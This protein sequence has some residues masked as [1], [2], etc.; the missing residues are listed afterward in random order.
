MQ[1]SKSIESVTSVASSCRGGEKKASPTH[2][3]IQREIDNKIM[4]LP[5]THL[6]N[7]S[8]TRIKINNTATFKVDNNSRK[9]YR[10]NIIQLGT[11]EICMEQFQVFE[12][13]AGADQHNETDDEIHETNENE[14]YDERK[15]SSKKQV[16]TSFKVHERI[17]TGSNPGL[18][19]SSTKQT[20]NIVQKK[21]HLKSKPSQIDEDLNEPS[22]NEDEEYRITTNDSSYNNISS[23]K[24]IHK[25]TTTTLKKNAKKTSTN[26]FQIEHQ[27]EQQRVSN[28]QILI[29][30]Q[31]QN[32]H[33][34]E[35]DTAVLVISNSEQE[36]QL[37]NIGSSDMLCRYDTLSKKCN[38][39]TKENAELQLECD[40]LTKENQIIKKSTMP[41]PDAAGRQWFINMGKYFSYKTTDTNIATHALNLGID[42]PR[43]LIACIEDTTSNTV[44]QVIR[45][46]YSSDKL[47]TMKGTEVPEDRRLIIRQF[48]ESQKGPIS[49]RTFNEAINGV[50]RSRKCEL[51][52]EKQQKK[53]S[54]AIEE[55]NNTNKHVNCLD[56]GQKTLIQMMNKNQHSKS[57]D[58]NY[59]K[60]NHNVEEIQDDNE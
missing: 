13:T 47:L 59:D 18:A 23:T 31:V 42:D 58:S 29:N 37:H 46:L 22:S 3:I 21:H 35:N 15:K 11:K 14:E 2:M 38:K 19:V 6:V 9:Q 56:K 16:P 5:V 34:R 1:R 20:T 45:H 57:N 32:I 12:M 26:E 10:G 7:I 30:S 55:N 24:S 8:V 41:I 27:R 36:Q 50:F 17:N 4:L 43:D 53:K 28:R 54:M 48:A 44:R 33:S 60:E 39:L 51:K 25:S 49:N 40:R 52:A